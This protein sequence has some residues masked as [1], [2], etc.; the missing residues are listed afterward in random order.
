MTRGN[1]VHKKGRH[2]NARNDD[3]NDE[4]N[5]PPQALTEPSLSAMP[6]SSSSDVGAKLDALMEKVD[7]NARHIDFL[8]DTYETRF[9]E[10]EHAM[11][12]FFDNVDQQ[13]Q[14]L[15]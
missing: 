15:L 6:S 13:N 3:E 2:D 4:E 11:T 14:Q 5:A 7:E 8:Q 9:V 12:A 1:Q 10:K